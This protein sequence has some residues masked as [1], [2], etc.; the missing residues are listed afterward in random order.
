VAILTPVF[1]SLAGLLA[2]WVA[3]VWP[4]LHLDPAQI[5]TFMT[6]AA[7]AALTAAWKW[8]RGWEQRERMVAEGK[9]VPAAEQRKMRKTAKEDA[10]A[11]AA[12]VA[13]KVV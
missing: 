7:V 10:A 8:L 11:K 5:V 12:K 13:E 6:A 1:A 2:G 3:S 4:G 9:T